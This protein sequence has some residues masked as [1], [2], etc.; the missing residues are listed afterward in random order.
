VLNHLDIALGSV[1]AHLAHATMPLHKNVSVKPVNVRSVLVS[2][3]RGVFAPIAFENLFSA[4]VL[5]EMALTS[6]SPFQRRS[7]SITARN[8]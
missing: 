2:P 3:H 7:R 5:S 8:I 1:T 6:L 4:E